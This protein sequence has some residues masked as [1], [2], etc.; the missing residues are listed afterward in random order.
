MTTTLKVYFGEEIRRV[1]LSDAPI[2]DD[3]KKTLASLFASTLDDDFHLQWKDE[4]GDTITVDSQLELEEAYKAMTENI[5]RFYVIPKKGTAKPGLTFIHHNVVCDNCNT[6]ISGSRFKCVNCANFDLCSSCE[7]LGVH[8]EDHLFL[9]INKPISWLGRRRPMPNLYETP[10]FAPGLFRRFVHAGQRGGCGERRFGK[11]RKNC[12]WRRGGCGRFFTFPV[13][14][15]PEPEVRSDEEVFMTLRKV[16]TP[17]TPVVQNEEST[18]P[19]QEK[20]EL[21]IDEPAEAVVTEEE[22]AVDDTTVEPEEASP[23][24]EEKQ[25]E[26]VTI[27]D[28][29][30]EEEPFAWQSQLDSLAAM[31]F[32]ETSRCAN[33]L[34]HYKGDLVKTVTALLS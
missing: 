14:S 29:E 26:S 16:P 10:N 15:A 28:V 18:A 7:V 23:V 12:A 4:E 31:G 24:E 3:L 1:T 22:P 20:D 9:K 21:P 6:T 19:V 32:T 33:Y 2:F 34:A 5:N 13:D 17:E 8:D 27:E 25:E 30:E 11:G